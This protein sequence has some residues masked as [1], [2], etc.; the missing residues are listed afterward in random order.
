MLENIETKTI[1]YKPISALTNWVQLAFIISAIIAVA[2]II[3]E[4]M[5]ADLL[6]GALHGRYVSMAQAIANDDREAI[7]GWINL[8][9]YIVTA[10][11]FLIW[12]YRANKNLHAFKSPVLRFSPGWAV[13]WWFIPFAN[14]F[15]PYQI[16]AEI[17][18]ASNPELDP[19]LNV[20]LHLPAPAIVGWWW[21]LFLIG[22]IV[23]SIAGELMSGANYIQDALNSTYTYVVADNINII[24]LIVAILMV[25]KISQS[26]DNR[27]L[28]AIE[29]TPQAA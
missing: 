11:I 23:T 12:V 5:Q 29:M 19:S 25:R 14:L 15:R 7:I 8:G 18:K 10:I 20:V 4:F 27:Y 6:I 16:T 21:A 9:I 28:K 1:R 13:G 17:S 2:S 24:G 3:S 22:N 26:Q